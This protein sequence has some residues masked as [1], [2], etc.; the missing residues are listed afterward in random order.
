MNTFVLAAMLVA[1]PPEQPKGKLV[2]VG[3]GSTS[4]PITKKTI[5]LAGGESCRM[6]ILPQSSSY[7]DAGESSEKHW[8]EH[9]ATNLTVVKWDSLIADEVT[10]AIEQV[11]KADLIWM[12]G[13]DQNRFM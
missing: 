6:V 2:V 11:K 9:G 1:A 10:R 8:R 3:G 5:E 4:G 13:G 12:P 7:P